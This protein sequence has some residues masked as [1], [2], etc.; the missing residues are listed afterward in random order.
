[1]NSLH[2]SA[3]FPRIWNIQELENLISIYNQNPEIHSSKKDPA[4]TNLLSSYQVLYV[5]SIEPII[6]D[7]QRIQQANKLLQRKAHSQNL[8]VLADC[9]SKFLQE[10]ALQQQEDS[11]A[12][13]LIL[14]SKKTSARH[15][16]Q[17]SLKEV[18][19]ESEP[20]TGDKKIF[21]GNDSREIQYTNIDKAVT[22]VID[23]YSETFTSQI[24]FLTEKTEKQNEQ[25]IQ[26]RIEELL[27]AQTDL[28]NFFEFN[29]YIQNIRI[30]IIKKLDDAEMDTLLIASHGGSLSQSSK[31]IINIAI[32]NKME[33][34][35]EALYAC[36][37][38][39]FESLLGN[40]KVCFYHQHQGFLD[41]KLKAITVSKIKSYYYQS[42]SDYQDHYFQNSNTG[43]KT[44][45]SSISKR[46]QKELVRIASRF[47]IDKENTALLL[48]ILK[49][50][51]EIIEKLASEE[52]RY[53]LLDKGY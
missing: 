11:K 16:L 27:K 33:T 31:D 39:Q 48:A 20:D 43:S 18:F 51:H 12:V 30:F 1:M 50:D 52:L 9:I 28:Q 15:G 37:N 6:G 45:G 5:E 2:D 23:E 34:I 40:N 35:A 21:M 25:E 4:I 46:E 42:N 24:Y 41:T 22:K 47:G 44:L 7:R 19:P 3:I 14:D 29:S 26:L 32:L 49:E 38:Q 8:N 53:R 17:A 13:N 36:N 10:K